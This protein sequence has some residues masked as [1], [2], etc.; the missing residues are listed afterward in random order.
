MVETKTLH[1]P[2]TCG[3]KTPII[4]NVCMYSRHHMLLRDFLIAAITQKIEP[5]TTLS[6]CFQGD[7]G[8]MTKG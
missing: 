3:I 2:H 6:Y 5:I 7:I 1:I 8:N 4:H